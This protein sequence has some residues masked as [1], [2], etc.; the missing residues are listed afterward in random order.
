MTT[1]LDRSGGL[2]PSAH[3]MSG[4]LESGETQAAAVWSVG[5]LMQAVA[6]ALAA[7]FNPLVVRGELAG[8]VRATSG[9][10]YFTL[11]DDAGQVR[12]A[13]FRRSANA[14][15][16][17]PREGD[18]V[19]VQGKLDVYGPRGDLQLIVEGLR[20]AGQGSLFE[21]FLQL[22]ARLQ[23]AGLFDA[24]RKKPIPA[25]P[26]SIGV[27][28]SL[29]AAALH[30]VATALQRRVPHIPVTLYPASVQ[31]VKAPTELCQAVQLASD[32]HAATGH[33]EVLLLVR[34]GG[35][36]EDLWAFNDEG[37]AYQL[38]KAPM[39]VVCG[40]GHESDITIA[41]FVADLRAPTPTAAAELCA[42]DRAVAMRSLARWAQ[43]LG[44]AADKGLAA[45]SLRVERLTRH[46]SRPSDVVSHEQQ[47]LNS[48]SSA[49][50]HSVHLRSS[51]ANQALDRLQERLLSARQRY[52]VRA[53]ER[54]D[55]QAGLM[56][57]LDP[58]LVLLRGYAWLTDADGHAVTRAAQTRKGQGLTASLADGEVELTVR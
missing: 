25:M 14:L 47:R 12:C 11:K 4:L 37:L 41:D 6:D 44:Q 18:S 3:G 48:L 29:G 15:T 16:W 26:R 49:L 1:A 43:Q 20:L 33:P 32:D 53:S 50:A 24:S 45:Q 56:N 28:T 57:A 13:M 23:A 55:H 34:G 54:L 36:L 40:V 21:R 30:D 46:M 7:R 39:A 22:K 35:S 52:M 9:H 2:V 31:G 51:H 27:V 5:H 19:E 17:S 10:C 38:A 42:T 8:F 58:R